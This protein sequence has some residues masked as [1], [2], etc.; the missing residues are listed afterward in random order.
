MSTDAVRAHLAP[1]GRDDGIVDL[2]A[3]GATVELAAAALGVAPERIAK[4]LSVYSQDG[5]RAVLIVTAGD[6]RLVS[7]EFKRRFGYKPRFLSADDVEPLTGHPIGGVCPFGNPDGTEV[8]LDESLR[9]F[10]RVYPAAGSPGTAIGIELA[11]LELL[12]GAAGW[13]A[14]TRPEQSAD[15]SS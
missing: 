1:F 5:S 12:S 15:S 10:E 11:E 2:P 6:A 9:R 7:G 14:I 4:T 3:S 8:W 13:V